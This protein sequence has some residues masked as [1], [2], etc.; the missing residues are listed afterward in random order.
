MLLG[1]ATLLFTFGGN[2]GFAKAQTTDIATS[3]P[4]VLVSILGEVSGT[5]SVNLTQPES[6]LSKQAIATLFAK[7]EITTLTP[8]NAVEY[9]V[10]YAVG[11]GI[12]A[13][14][15]VLILLA[16]II[17]SL[18]LFTR[19]IIGLP[20]LDMF[21]PTALAYAFIAVG[22]GPGLM[23]MGAVVLAAIISRSFLRRMPIMTLAKRSLTHFAL[24]FFVFAALTLAIALG[25]DSVKEL[26]IFPILILML[27]GD[28]ITSVQLRKTPRETILVSGVTISLGIIGYLLATSLSIRDTLLLWPEI[29]LLVLPINFMIGRYFGLR[30]TEIFRFNTLETHGSE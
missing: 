4:N 3:T 7:R 16:P 12:P 1:A 19:T 27:L 8:F 13:N 14:T 25:F 5:P 26:S 11:L 23:I 15:I 2:L 6:T 21:V 9:W 29:I 20:S 24:A 22:I 28:S 18:V 17:A 30:L 10:R